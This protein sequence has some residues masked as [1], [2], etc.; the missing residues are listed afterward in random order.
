MA[1]PLRELDDTLEEYAAAHGMTLLKDSRNQPARSL[2]WGRG[3]QRTI[4]ITYD[5]ETKTG[6]V[7][8]CAW[9]DR[10]TVKR[11]RCWKQEHLDDAEPLSTIKT[12]LPR[13]LEEARA[14]VE[15]W[16]AGDLNAAVPEPS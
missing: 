13:L 1:A 15:A 12:Q 11:A 5:D 6:H 7:W 9:Q 10:G 2:V 4:Q 3:I 8:L 14:V 16:S